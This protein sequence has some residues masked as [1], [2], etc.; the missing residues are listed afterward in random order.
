MISLVDVAC[1]FDS[2]HALKDWLCGKKVP[3]EGSGRTIAPED[4]SRSHS[5][6]G[7]QRFRLPRRCERTL[8]CLRRA[9]IGVL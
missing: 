2:S 3:K 7:I 9:A 6:Q 4:G 1:P 8:A 5:L